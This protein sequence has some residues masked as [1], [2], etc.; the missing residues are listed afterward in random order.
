MTLVSS[1]QRSL[2]NANGF[3]FPL[4]SSRQL[5]KH[6]RVI[7]RSLSQLD[8]KILQSLVFQHLSATVCPYRPQWTFL[9]SS[10]DVAQLPPTTVSNE[11]SNVFTFPFHFQM[12]SLVFA[13]FRF[14][15]AVLWASQCE[16]QSQYADGRSTGKLW[17]FI[18]LLLS[19]PLVWQDIVKLSHN[20]FYL[21]FGLSNVHIMQ[22]RFKWRRGFWA[23]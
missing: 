14:S 8:C 9:I 1:F 10:D 7:L 11:Y 17:R 15:F 22:L 19:L 12:D 3:R 23:F 13:C 21:W 4:P 18:L 5:S 16:G 2:P 6:F 20:M